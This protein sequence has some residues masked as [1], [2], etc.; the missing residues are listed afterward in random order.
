VTRVDSAGGSAVTH[1]SSVVPGLT[2]QYS[3]ISVVIAGLDP[4]IHPFG[5]GS[6]EVLRVH[7]SPTSSVGCGKPPGA[8]APGS[9]L[10]TPAPA[11]PASW[12]ARREDPPLSTLRTRHLLAL[13]PRRLGLDQPLHP[14]RQRQVIFLCHPHG[15]G[16][17][18]WA[19][20]D[21][22]CGDG[23][24]LFHISLQDRRRSLSGEMNAAIRFIDYTL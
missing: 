3:H 11:I 13:Q 5:K 2:V 19:D 10:T 7:R 6:C 9:A 21:A 23:G 18:G 1:R 16:L 24:L 4:A 8:N 17:D 14:P 20:A 22:E 15:C 12:W